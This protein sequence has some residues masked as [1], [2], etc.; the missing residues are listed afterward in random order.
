MD[1]LYTLLAQRNERAITLTLLDPLT[2]PEGPH[3]PL[4][5]A[6]T[7]GI[8]VYVQVYWQMIPL[9]TP[10][11][12][13]GVLTRIHRLIERDPPRSPSGPDWDG[14]PLDTFDDPSY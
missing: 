1:V 10:A 14:E 3:T 5:L 2:V 4:R 8:E 6:R 11:E 12:R 9:P 13:V 7:S